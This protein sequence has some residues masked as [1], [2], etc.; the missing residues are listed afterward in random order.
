MKELC[1]PCIETTRLIFTVSFFFS[2]SAFLHVPHFHKPLS[3]LST[4][5]S[6]PKTRKPQALI[7]WWGRC[8]KPLTILVLQHW[9]P[10]LGHPG[11]RGRSAVSR[12]LHHQLC[13]LEFLRVTVQELHLGD[14]RLGNP[15]SRAAFIPTIVRTLERAS[16]I[17]STAR[18]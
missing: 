7:L 15:C 18:M 3:C 9:S 6:P 2:H 14:P 1:I 10:T 12:G 13:Y 5:L 16:R 4:V 11:V 17:R 8:S